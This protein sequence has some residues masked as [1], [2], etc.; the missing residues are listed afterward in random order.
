MEKVEEVQAEDLQKDRKRCFTCSKKVGLLGTECKCCFVF[1]NTH[2]LPE[3]HN[4]K[5]DFRVRGQK[6]LEKTVVKVENGKIAK[7]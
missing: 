3:A 7:I 1:C 6:E 5:I 2:R 4:C